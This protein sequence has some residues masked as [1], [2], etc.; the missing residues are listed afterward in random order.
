MNFIQENT[1]KIDLGLSRE[2]TLIQFN[3]VHVTTYDKRLDDSETIDRA[4]KQEKLWMKQRLDFANKFNEPYDSKSMLPSMECFKQL[5]EY[6]NENHPDLVIM[7]GD[8]IDYYSRSN[9]DFLVKSIGCGQDLFL[10]IQLSH[11]NSFANCQK[12]K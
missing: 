7:A 5:I 4:I 12:A 3:D 10:N 9:Y 8:I 6:A 2:Y 1:V 11:P